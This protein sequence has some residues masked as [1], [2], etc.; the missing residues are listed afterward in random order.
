MAEWGVSWAHMFK[1]EKIQE[2][3]RWWESEGCLQRPGTFA[4][5]E[6]KTTVF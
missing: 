6:D 3:E 4:S 1:V 5:S 2:H